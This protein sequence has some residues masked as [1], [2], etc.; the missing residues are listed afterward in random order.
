MTSVIRSISAKHW[1]V[2]EP[3]SVSV[4]HR[5]LFSYADEFNK[6]GLERYSD[7]FNPMPEKG[8]DTLPKKLK[9]DNMIGTLS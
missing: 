1:L 7:Y 9:P 3:T 6:R 4:F 8:D 5:R 2:I